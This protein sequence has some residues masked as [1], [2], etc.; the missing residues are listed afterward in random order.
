MHTL[1]PARSGAIRIGNGV[2]D[3]SPIDPSNA[4]LCILIPLNIYYQASSTLASSRPVTLLLSTFGFFLLLSLLQF[5][6]LYIYLFHKLTSLSLSLY[7]YIYICQSLSLSISLSQS[8]SLMH[9]FS[10]FPI[11]LAILWGLYTR[12]NMMMMV[13]SISSTAI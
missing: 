3:N 11:S 2:K 9:F 7:I 12:H 1:L 13:S 4:Y 10:F 5:I 8:L 6:C